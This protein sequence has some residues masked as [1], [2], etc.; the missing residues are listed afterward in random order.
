MSN[1]SNVHAFFT[2]LA[3]AVA[4]SNNEPSLEMLHSR[5]TERPEYITGSLQDVLTKAMSRP[6]LFAQELRDYGVGLPP[7]A[8][9]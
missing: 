2:K 5:K 6:S 9:C 8:H 4:S 7:M 3:A 1:S